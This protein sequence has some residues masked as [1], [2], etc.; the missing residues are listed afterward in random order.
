MIES[1][2]NY[3]GVILELLTQYKAD[4]TVLNNFAKHSYFKAVER[5]LKKFMEGREPKRTS[6]YRKSM[7]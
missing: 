1:T 3:C 7:I 6:Y 5:E 4:K 2:K